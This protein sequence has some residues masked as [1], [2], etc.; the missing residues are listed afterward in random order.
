MAKSKDWEA[1]ADQISYTIEGV[2]INNKYATFAREFDVD[3]DFEGTSDLPGNVP[4]NQHIEVY[5]GV[6]TE[7]K[8]FGDYGDKTEYKVSFKPWGEAAG[9][10]AY[11]PK[12]SGVLLKNTSD[13]EQKFYYRIGEK[14]SPAT[15]TPNNVLHGVTL[16]KQYVRKETG[17][18][19][20]VLQGGLFRF[21]PNGYTQFIMDPHRAYLVLEN[22]AP[23]AGAPD[24]LS[25]Y[26]DGDI[27]TGIDGVNAEIS[28]P[29]YYNLQGV[30]T[31]KPSRGLYLRNGQK[32]FI[33]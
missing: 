30:R 28:A 29:V 31:T 22:A 10:K 5:A 3:F 18:R 25:I 7:M 12:G 15:A 21:V 11:V 2:A 14:A 27:T 16:N 6:G 24:V 19:Y 9:K 23:A 8:G 13:T 4:V 17:K 26:T 33:H 1:Y 32:T 20:Y